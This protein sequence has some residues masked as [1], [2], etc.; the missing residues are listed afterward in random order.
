VALRIYIFKQHKFRFK[1][2]PNIVNSDWT[3]LVTVNYG[4]LDFFMN[5]LHFYRK[6]NLKNKIIAIA[7]D[8]IVYRNLTEIENIWKIG[9]Y[10]HILP[11]EASSFGTTNFS[12]LVSE[13]PT[14][15]LK[16]LKE[17]MDIIYTDVDTIWLQNP[18]PFLTG[19]YDI[20]MP[21]YGSHFCTGFIAI[22]CTKASKSMM[23]DWEAELS[24][25]LQ[26]NQKGFTTVLRQNPYIRIKPLN[27]DEFPN[28]HMYFDWF[29]NQKRERT[30]VVHNNRI[31]GHDRKLERF[32]RFGMW[33]AN[34]NNV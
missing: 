8:E 2:H 1:K 34:D 5:W 9:K 12:K 15:I 17:K 13:R 22:N 20:W 19:E 33:L 10:S 30:I 31:T 16:Y 14:H 23:V 25:V 26:I 6:L 4:F 27:C 29:S 24:R 11:N 3:I 18:I 32:K 21:Q 7:Q 28:G